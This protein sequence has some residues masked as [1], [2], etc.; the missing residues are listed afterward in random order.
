MM[1]RSIL[2]FLCNVLQLQD[3]LVDRGRLVD[4]LQ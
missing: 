4:I 3:F 2:T 1:F